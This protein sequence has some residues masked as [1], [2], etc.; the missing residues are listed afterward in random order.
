MGNASYIPGQYAARVIG[1]A[2]GVVSYVDT[3]RN[4][5]I[6][7]VVKIDNEWFHRRVLVCIGMEF[8]AVRELPRSMPLT[9][10]MVRA[11]HKAESKTPAPET[12]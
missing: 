9:D 11:I 3:A 8:A 7:P 1:K 2:D 4:V 5:C 10:L 6:L 12:T